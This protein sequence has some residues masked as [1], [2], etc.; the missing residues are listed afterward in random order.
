M[1]LHCL[2]HLIITARC[3]TDKTYTQK[4]GKLYTDYLEYCAQI[5]HYKRNNADFK[6]AL[7]GA[8]FKGSYKHWY[9]GHYHLDEDTDE[10]HTCVFDKM[11]CLSGDFMI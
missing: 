1:A 7:L 4:G 6:A 8:G 10:K 9:F 2:Y 3:E 5:G 11:I